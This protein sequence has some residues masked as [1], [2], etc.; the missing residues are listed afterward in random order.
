MDN[1]MARHPR[2]GYRRFRHHYRRMSKF[3]DRS[4]VKIKW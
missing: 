4:L 3:K 1:N 2:L